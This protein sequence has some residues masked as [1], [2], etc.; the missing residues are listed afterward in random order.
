MEK[1][2]IVSSN[3]KSGEL[4]LELLKPQIVTLSLSLSGSEARRCLIDNSYDLIVVNTPLKDEFGHEL[5][6]QAAGSSTAGILL[7]VKAEMADEISAKVED[8]GVFVISKPISRAFFYQSLKLVEASRR[9]LLELKSENITLQK[10]IEEIRLVD[11]AKCVLIQY[12]KLS[13]PQAHRYIEKQAMDMRQTRRE[14]AE[15][16]LKTYES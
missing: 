3:G 6:L 9:R 2:L 1:A 5:A 4:L 8:Y 14:I 16:I 13:E 15:Q 10:K 12:L 7:L 11:R